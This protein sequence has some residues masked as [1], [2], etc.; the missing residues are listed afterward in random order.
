MK[1]LV[2]TGRMTLDS[3]QCF[4]PPIVNSSIF[5]ITPTA[6]SIFSR[7]MHTTKPSLSSCCE[8]VCFSEGVG[9]WQQRE[10]WEKEMRGSDR[11]GAL[12]QQGWPMPPGL[13]GYFSP[14]TDM[15]RQKPVCAN[16]AESI[17]H[18]THTHTHTEFATHTHTQF[19][20]HTHTHSSRSEG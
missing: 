5:H 2:D 7:C 12:E 6:L 16:S 11:T 15:Q 3:F 19:A 20:T 14:D 9:G 18:A 13:L 4:R 1:R 8:C 10:I 17:F